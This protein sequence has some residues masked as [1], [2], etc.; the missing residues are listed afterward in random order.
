LAVRYGAGAG[1]I[2]GQVPENLILAAMHVGANRTAKLKFNSWERKFWW[3]TGGNVP[4]VAEGKSH[5]GKD[6]I[7]IPH[8]RFIS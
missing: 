6:L 2:L 3:R 4:V 7:R 1:T 8:V 5:D